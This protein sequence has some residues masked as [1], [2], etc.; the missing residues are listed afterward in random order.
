MY[1]ILYASP[2]EIII[3]VDTDSRC[4]E[5]TNQRIPSSFIFAYLDRYLARTLESA[6]LRWL[7]Q[8]TPI[9][10]IPTGKRGAVVT[11]AFSP[12]HLSHGLAEFDREKLWA[13]D[14]DGTWDWTPIRDLYAKRCVIC[15]GPGYPDSLI[16]PEVADIRV[17]PVNADAPT[18]ELICRH[19]L[20]QVKRQNAGLIVPEVKLDNKRKTT[21]VSEATSP[22]ALLREFQQECPA[23]YSALVPNENGE[24]EH[25]P[26]YHSLGDGGY[27]RRGVSED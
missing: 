22:A 11:K 15:D 5:A 8:G 10:Q 4:E 27:W 18:G 12:P 23:L 20:R 21:A 14:D 25:I 24:D 1:R 13:K 9:Q 17:T 3:E 2:S 19:C 7:I 16:N 6:E 26:G